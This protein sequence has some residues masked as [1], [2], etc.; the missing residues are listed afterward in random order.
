[1]GAQIALGFGE[2]MLILLEVEGD[3]MQCHENCDKLLTYL[4]QFQRYGEY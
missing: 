4:F 3:F 1:M 2:H